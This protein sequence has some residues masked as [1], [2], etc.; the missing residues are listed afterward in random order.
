MRSEQ[1]KTYLDV[2][3]GITEL[4]SSTSKTVV[5]GL[6]NNRS[7]V[8][9]VFMDTT[10]SSWQLLIQ[11]IVQT[12]AICRRIDTNFIMSSTLSERVVFGHTH[13]Y[14]DVHTLTRMLTPTHLHVIYVAC[15]GYSRRAT[16]A[17]PTHI[18]GV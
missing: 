12:R 5:S 8:A 9:M 18:L 10:D 11:T 4:V 16:F 7:T 2:G 3:V 6:G 15:I 17:T 14:P 1:K 13:V